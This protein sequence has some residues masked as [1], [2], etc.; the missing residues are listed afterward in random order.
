MNKD[1]CVGDACRLYEGKS[2]IR[3]MT[4]EDLEFHRLNTALCVACD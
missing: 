3:T 4:D 1:V 2:P